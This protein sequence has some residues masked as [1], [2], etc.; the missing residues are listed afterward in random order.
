MCRVVGGWEEDQFVGVG[1]FVGCDRVCD[2]VWIC[3]GCG[4]HL[5]CVLGCVVVIVV[6]C[7]L[8]RVVGVE[9]ECEVG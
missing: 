7:L 8:E 6:E 2:R 3:W 9:I 4:D 1:C 5:G